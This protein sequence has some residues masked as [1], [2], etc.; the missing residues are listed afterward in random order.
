[1]K[2][3]T[4]QRRQATRSK[5]PWEHCISVSVNLLE[6]TSVPIKPERDTNLWLMIVSWKSLPLS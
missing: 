6:I 4:I 1:M 5:D 2:L 3:F